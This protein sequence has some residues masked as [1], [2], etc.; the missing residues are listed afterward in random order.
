MSNTSLDKGK[1]KVLLLEGI[2]PSSVA[3]LEADGYT[4]IEFHR[5]SLPEDRLIEA[6]NSPWKFI[7]RQSGCLLYTS[8]CV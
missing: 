4:Q 1:I 2:H 5:K 6:K 7:V 3:T 8:R